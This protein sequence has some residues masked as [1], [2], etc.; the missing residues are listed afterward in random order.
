MFPSDANDLV[1]YVPRDY[2]HDYQTADGWS[3][4]AD[5]IVGYDFENGVVV[6]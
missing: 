3:S 1:I 2:V 6:E 5:A 4:Y